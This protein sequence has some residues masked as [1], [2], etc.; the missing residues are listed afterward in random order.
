MILSGTIRIRPTPKQRPRLTKGGRA[1]NPQKTRDAQRNQAFF[2]RLLSRKSE[3]NFPISPKLPLEI[4]LKFFTKGG[5]AGQP[6]T[7]VPDTDN[8]CKLTLDAIV[9]SG[10]I[11]CDSQ[12]TKLILEDY[13]AGK[14]AESKIVFSIQEHQ[15]SLIEEIPV[16][17]TD[18]M[19]L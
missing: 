4:T 10:I 12:V 6:K 13:W 18:R 19:A 8:L 11:R 7:T 5:V 16:E 14:G 15:N 3:Y 17:N 1:R 9:D 2:F